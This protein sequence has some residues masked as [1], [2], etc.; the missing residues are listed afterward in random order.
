VLFGLNAID[1]KFPSL[2]DSRVL[3]N[4]LHNYLPI[5]SE[6]PFV[7]LQSNSCS[8]ASR[9]LLRQGTAEPGEHIQL[10]SK[11]EKEIWMEIQVEPNFA[12]KGRQF[13]FKSPKLRLALWPESGGRPLVKMVAP[14][15]MLACGF[16]I[17]PVL[18]NN[19]DVLA[20]Y[21]NVPPTRPFA[22][23]VEPESGTAS[24]WKNHMTYR[25]Y[26]IDDGR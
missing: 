5:E 4:L 3:L 1:R 2:E 15:P 25:I 19:S 24:F 14:A 16:L 13:F 12:G 10:Q 21:S 7:L 11:D 20:Y 8:Q 26:R 23:S 6:G 9:T 22:C 17:S 18:L